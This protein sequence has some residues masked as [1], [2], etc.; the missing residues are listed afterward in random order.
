M[1]CRKRKQ[2]LLLGRERKS[3]GDRKPL[4]RAQKRRKGR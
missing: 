3:S 2:R 4:K 1:T